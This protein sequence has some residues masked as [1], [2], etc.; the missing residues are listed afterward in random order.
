MMNL[1]KIGR[2][3]CKIV[4]GVTQTEFEATALRCVKNLNN[5]IVS[6]YDGDEEDISKVFNTMTLHQGK[7]QHIPDTTKERG[8]LYISGP[9]GSGKTTY[10]KNYI[11]ACR[12]YNKKMKVYL[13]S[14]LDSDESLD[15]VGPLR[16]KIDN[17]L[18]TDP[19]KLDEFEKGSMIIF[20][21][22][23][24]ISDKNLRDA[25]YKISNQVLEIGRHYHLSAIFT[26]H[27][28]TGGNVT[29]RILNECHAVIYFPHSGSMRG[30]NYLLQ[31]YVG[32]DK[33]DIKNI[34][35]LKSRWACIF[36][37]YPQI[38]MTEKNIFVLSSDD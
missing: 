11:K 32:L 26:N 10:T 31:S 9:S 34:K 1:E 2:P 33:K 37:N 3:L 5:K 14:A 15:E 25:V 24:V 21:D 4:N 17:S 27:L 7:F 29:K 8:I 38:C 23:D 22:V 19:I 13:F 30:L 35:K 20:D 6:V 28:S 36:K 16:V 18:I 12:V